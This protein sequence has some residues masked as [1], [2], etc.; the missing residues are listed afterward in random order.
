MLAQLG[1]GRTLVRITR[2][3]RAY[4]ET[5]RGPEKKKTYT[6]KHLCLKSSANAESVIPDGIGGAC[7]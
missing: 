6:A 1:S 2:K 5:L 4:Q 7:F 3:K